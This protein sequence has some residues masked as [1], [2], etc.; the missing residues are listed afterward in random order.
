MVGGQV[1]SL[2]DELVYRFEFPERPGALLAFLR[3]IGDRW[4]ISLFHYRNHGS[5]YGRVLAGVQVPPVQRSKFTE[6]LATLGYPYW[7]E[8]D[9]PAYRLFLSSASTQRV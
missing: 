8:T 4:N 5:D 2:E 7:D 3:A 1:P 9:N 6:H